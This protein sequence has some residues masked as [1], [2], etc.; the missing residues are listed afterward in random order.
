MTVPAL[1]KAVALVDALAVAK[2]P[3]FRP[4]RTTAAD[5]VQE[6]A[7]ER[8]RERAREAAQE[9]ATQL[10]HSPAQIAVRPAVRGLALAG[11]KGLVMVAPQHALADAVRLA[12]ITVTRS[13]CRPARRTVEATAAERASFPVS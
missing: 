7:Q 10:A 1:A 12:K 3:V 5:A 8:A 6:R 2:L 11:A 9:G 4:A 13:A